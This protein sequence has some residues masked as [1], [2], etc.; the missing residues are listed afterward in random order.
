MQPDQI[1]NRSASSQ[2][3]EMQAAP[4]VPSQTSSG[5][6]RDGSAKAFTSG[7]IAGFLG[8]SGWAVRK[9]L[10]NVPAEKLSTRAGQAAKGW[11]LAVLPAKWQSA[12]AA[13]AKRKGYRVPEDMLSDE[14][15][16]L[17]IPPVPFA[18]I[19]ERFQGEAIQ[20]R[21]ALMPILPDQQKADPGELCKRGLE[22][23]R[24]VFGREVAESTW[25]QHFD[26][27]V[28]R[29][30]GFEEWARTEIYTPAEAF[31]HSGARRSARAAIEAEDLAELTAAFSQVANPSKLTVEDRDFIWAALQKSQAP[32]NALLDYAFSSLPGLAR[33]RKALAKAF[34]RK[35]KSP[36][37]GRPGKSGRPGTALC[38]KC[39]PLMTGTSRDLDGDMAQAWRRLHLEKKLCA[40]CTGLWHYDVRS[41]KSY[42]PLAVRNQVGPDVASALASRHGPKWARLVSPYVL[43]RR[44][45]GPGDV[46]EGD[47]VTWNHE[48][49]LW[50]TDERG[51]PYVGRGEC[52]LF[53]DRTS[54]YPVGY[55]LIAGGVDATG[56]QIAARYTG[57]DIR[58]GVLHVHDRVGLPRLGF[59]FENGIWK[60]RLVAGRSIKGWQSNKWREFERGLNE[61]GIM[62]GGGKSTIRHAL[63]GSPRT[64][65]IERMIRAV[66]ERM[67]P[68]PGFVGFNHREYKPELLNDFLR[69]VMTG[70]EHPGDMFLSLKQF[71]DTL[72]S[73]LMAYAQ[74][75]QNGQWLPGV[76]PAEV[77][78]NGIGQFAGV[79]DKPLRKLPPSARHLLAT[80][81]RS[82]QV[83]GQGIRFE[84]GSRPRVFWG[85]E[86]IPWKYKM[87][88]VR[89]NIE[90]PELLHCLPPGGTPFTMIARE[91]N[92]W[93]ASPPELSKT[94]ADRN[95]W[96][97][98]GRA[99]SDNLPHPFLSSVTRD[100]EHSAAVHA[101]GEAIMRATEEHRR[102]KA[103]VVNESRRLAR[104]A[105]TLGMSVPSGQTVTARAIEAR[106]RRLARAETTP[107]IQL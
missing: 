9:W 50:D 23:C 79:A 84:V 94:G 15:S 80:H 54:W 67:R 27:A 11:A 68:L 107:E 65:I 2:N 51:K 72:D 69:R 78:K 106:K 74:E 28:R 105:G 12:L 36:Q 20:W 100:T 59:Q 95:R 19:P 75:P 63:P 10:R 66:Q 25:R 30:N 76:C 44:D 37:D 5:P 35:L 29:D 87:L 62:L 32:R 89:W 6:A 98:H 31:E 48:F 49:Y 96:I 83:T 14:R 70:K 24:R 47:D 46:F 90:E 104:L 55:R 40:K 4:D 97:Q 22:E 92:S 85:D 18:Q 7:Q 17:W 1:S 81:W 38:P 34:R 26:L 21:N 73:E 77:W 71:R 91:L 60:S 39:K 45:I 42:V 16:A 13:I 103:A 57:V 82:V 41:N 3:Q 99:I 64:K 88:P 102:Q 86:L 52:L 43:R 93:T 61:E 33:T 58:L 8:L 53:L 56:K 101:E